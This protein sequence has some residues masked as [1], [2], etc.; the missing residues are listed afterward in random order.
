MKEVQ[1]M[2]DNR[3]GMLEAKIRALTV[4]QLHEWTDTGS[5][6]RGQDYCDHVQVLK[7]ARRINKSKADHNRLDGCHKV[8][9]VIF[10]Q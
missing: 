8:N 9:S 3:W 4:T 2:S 5:V 7:F 1:Q 6:L 10:L